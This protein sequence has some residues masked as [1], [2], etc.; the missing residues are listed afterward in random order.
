MPFNWYSKAT[1]RSLSLVGMTAPY[2]CEI[3]FNIASLSTFMYSKLCVSLGEVGG[4]KEINHLGLDGNILK[5]I[6]KKSVGRT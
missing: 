5:W 1:E 6:F 4:V 3:Y 2:L